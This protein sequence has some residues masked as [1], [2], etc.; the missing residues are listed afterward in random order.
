M[1]NEISAIKRACD[2]IEEKSGEFVTRM[3]VSIS[4][5]EDIFQVAFMTESNIPHELRE[6][7]DIMILNNGDWQSIGEV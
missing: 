6:D 3:T 2:F 1:M 5:E 7:G 4:E